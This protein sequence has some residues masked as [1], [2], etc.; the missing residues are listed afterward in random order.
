MGHCLCWVDGGRGRWE[1]GITVD[2]LDM[3]EFFGF[4]GYCFFQLSILEGRGS[5]GNRK[6]EYPC[7][8]KKKKSEI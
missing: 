8:L 1:R 2:F 5:K 4:F 3:F 6:T 7:E